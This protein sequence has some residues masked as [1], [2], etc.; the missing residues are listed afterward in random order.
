[1]AMVGF[2]DSALINTDSYGD[3]VGRFSESAL[4]TSDSYSTYRDNPTTVEDPLSRAKSLITGGARVI[5]TDELL[6]AHAQLKQY[7]NGLTRAAVKAWEE[8]EIILLYANDPK[9][10]M[11]ELVPF[12]TIRSGG[13]Y[14]G[15]IF[16]NKWI[17]KPRQPDRLG[18]T[19]SINSSYLHDLLVGSL[20]AR[21]I[22]SDYHRLVSSPYLESMLMRLYTEFAWRLLVRRFG[23]GADKVAGDTVKYYLNRFFTEKVFESKSSPEDI[24][25]LTKK[26]YRFIDPMKS[27]EMTRA[28]NEASPNGLIELLALISKLA[29]TLAGLTFPIF[30]NSWMDYYYPPA[31]LAMDNVDY[32]IFMITTL[33]NVS[34]ICNYLASDIVKDAKGIRTFDEELLKL[35]Q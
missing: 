9:Q 7:S 23:I 22:R 18:T 26:H 19:L 28:Y 21:A 12:L 35:I 15:Y 27:D 33:K 31:Y 20:V 4:S 32:L 1:M 24:E 13:K 16:M 30:M 17:G 8:G 5:G 11:I 10:S 6:T 34:G 3:I 2:N 14:T 25:T 29:D